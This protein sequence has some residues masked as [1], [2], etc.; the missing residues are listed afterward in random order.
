M[1][2]F[3]RFTNFIFFLVLHHDFITYIDF[4]DIEA[5]NTADDDVTN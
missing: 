1:Y 4:T 5:L 2:K 3:F